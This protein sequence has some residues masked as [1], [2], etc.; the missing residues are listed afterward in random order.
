MTG[1]GKSTF[2]SEIGTFVVE[3]QSVNR[4]HLEVVTYMP[5]EFFCMEV[6]IKKEVARKL[7]RGQI[8]IRMT[9]VPNSKMVENLLPDIKFLQ[10]MKEGWEGLAK[11]IGIKEEISLSFLQE[12]LAALSQTEIKAP[13]EDSKGSILLCVNQAT[14]ALIEAKEE[15][16]KGLYEDIH[17]RLNQIMG[18]IQDISQKAPDMTSLYREKLRL[19]TEELIGKSSDYED[20][21]AREVVLF[22]ERVDI[23]EEL[24]RFRVHWDKFQKLIRSETS[25]GREMDFLIQE[26]NREINTLS[27]KA[28]D[29]TIS[30]YAVQIKCTLEKIREQTQNIE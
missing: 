11:K 13:I 25:V 29:A 9:F 5:R 7:V 24:V 20:R 26:M 4:K 1:F 12:Q 10:A 23:T 30:T 14:D 2:S 28:L 22:A 18:W 3:I 8:T 27:T 15:E 17:S 19:R 16:G 6:D 21:I